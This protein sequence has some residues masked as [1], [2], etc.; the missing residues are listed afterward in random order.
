MRFV[1][2]GINILVSLLFNWNVSIIICCEIFNR[3]FSGDISG[4]VIVV[5]FEFEDIKKLNIFW[6]NSIF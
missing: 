5:C 1:E 3:L 6:N 4:I 2:V